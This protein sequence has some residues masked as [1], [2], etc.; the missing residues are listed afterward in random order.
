MP[1]VVWHGLLCAPMN[2]IVRPIADQ[3]ARLFNLTRSQ[4]RTLLRNTISKHRFKLGAVAAASA[5]KALEK[6]SAVEEGFALTLRS[7]YLVEWMN[8]E[9]DRQDKGSPPLSPIRERV[10]RYLAAPSSYELLCTA[11]GATPVEAA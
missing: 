10:S 2:W 7:A 4:A 5:K 9:L 11:Y 6:A 1:L 3:V 8:L